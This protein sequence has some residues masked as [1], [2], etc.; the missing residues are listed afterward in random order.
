VDEMTA[1]NVVADKSGLVTNVQVFSGRA[2]VLAGTVVEEGDL[3]IGISFPRYTSRSIEAMEF[4][5][6]QGASLIAITDGPLSPLH[7]AADIW[8]IYW[9]KVF[10]KLQSESA[11]TRGNGQLRPKGWSSLV[12]K[13]ETPRDMLCPSLQTP[14]GRIICTVSVW[15]RAALRRKC[16]RLS[17]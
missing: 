11:K 5:H 7:S 14:E 13:Q 15:R 8:E 2:A 9:Q 6:R 10:G 16:G 1:R 12:W 17:V 4:A 3:L